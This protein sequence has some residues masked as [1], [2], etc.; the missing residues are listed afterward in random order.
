MANNQSL[1]ASGDIHKKHNWQNVYEDTLLFSEKPTSYL[2][3]ALGHKKDQHQ[4]DGITDT[5]IRWL[6][7]NPL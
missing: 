7:L 2:I 6:L 4:D 5:H 3:V 1:V